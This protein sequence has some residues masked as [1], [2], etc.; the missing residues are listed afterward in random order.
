MWGV[1]VEDTIVRPVDCVVHSSSFE[2]TKTYGAR[3]IIKDKGVQCCQEMFYCRF[4]P[5]TA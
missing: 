3:E 2:S 1:P 4:I 5:I